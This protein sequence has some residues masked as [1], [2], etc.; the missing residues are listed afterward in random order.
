[1]MGDL[2]EDPAADQQVKD[3]Y[4]ALL[5]WLGVKSRAEIAV[6]HQREVR[7]GQRGVFDGRQ[8]AG[9]G[10]ARVFQR[11]KAW[12][13]GVYRD[14]ANLDVKLVDDVQRCVRPHH[15]DQEIEAAKRE[16]NVLLFPD[17]AAVA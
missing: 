9:T 3:D 14:I 8:R 7:P 4:A 15:T 6:E 13:V 10:T 5:G 1:M 12:L 17:A 16:V 11:F 2:A